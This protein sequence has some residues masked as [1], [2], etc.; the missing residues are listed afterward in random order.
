M[1]PRA[2]L[3]RRTSPPGPEPPVTAPLALSLSE[4]PGHSVAPGRARRAIQ[5]HVL[6]AWHMNPRMLSGRPRACR[7]V[8]PNVRAYPQPASEAPSQLEAPVLSRVTRRSHWAST[9]T[10]SGT[11]IIQ[12]QS[13]RVLRYLGHVFRMDADRTPSLLQ[14]CWLV[15]GK[16]PS[17]KT[18]VLQVTIPL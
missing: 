16:Q 2:A 5:R 3:P 14:R 17:G 18:K 13:S 1:A 7:R 11:M 8:V 10:T 12:V 4:R 9:G 6:V 15:D